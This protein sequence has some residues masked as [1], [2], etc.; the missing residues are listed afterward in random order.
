MAGLMSWCGNCPAFALGSYVVKVKLRFGNRAVAEVTRHVRYLTFFV[1]D[2]VSSRNRFQVRKRAGLKK[3]GEFDACG[4]PAR[5]GGKSFGGHNPAMPSDSRLTFFARTDFHDLKKV[6]GIR[7]A[8]RR[9]HMYVIGKTGTGKSTLLETL[10]RQDIEAG[11]GIALLDPHGDIVERIVSRVPER[12]RDDV[13]YFNVPDA[14]HPL[15]F[16]PL[17]QVPAAKRPLTASGLLEVFKKLWP[18]FWGPRLEHILRNA[19]L[20]LL[21]QPEATLADVLRLFDDP[22]YRKRVSERV[23]NAQVRNFWIR[24]YESYPKNLKAEAIA[25]IQNKVGAFLANPIL[26]RIV[27]QPKSTFDVR[28]VMDEG[29]LL[30][31]NLAKGKIGE[32]TASLLGA[33]LVTRIGVAALSRADLP[34]NQRRDFYIYMDEFQSFTTLSIA[35]MLSELRKY[36]AGMI[37][38]HQYLYQLDAQIREAILG[39]VGTIIS[40][41]LGASDAQILKREFAPEIDAADLISLSNYHIYLKLMVEG[42]ITRPFSARTVKLSNTT[43]V[44]RESERQ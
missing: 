19:L 29:N 38:A 44:S 7:R 2:V 30:L 28:R 33:L 4:K 25:P 6:F 40:F 23:A 22:A 12:R 42:E 13:I 24:E 35:N 16:N 27:T 26:N 10:I 9:A 39:N 18:E 11:E 21:D 3:K 17:E 37:L 32:D 31:V 36:R 1:Q 15:G 43:A 8:D 41:R 20:A 14:L 5:L 34:E